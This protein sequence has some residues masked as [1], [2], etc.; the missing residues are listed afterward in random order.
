M[1]GRVGHPGRRRTPPLRRYGPDFTMSSQQSVTDHSGLRTRTEPE[2][3]KMLP[4]L[5]LAP[6]PHNGRLAGAWWPRTDQPAA[7][8]TVLVT[9][10]ASRGVIATRLSLGARAWDGTPG[11]IRFPDRDVRLIWF[12]HRAPHTVIVGYGADEI[13]LLVIPPQSTQKVAS[14]AF[15]LATDSGNISGPDKILAASEAATP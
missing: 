13:A 10:L 7:E 15:R 8:L 9:G 4:R 14:R 12:S 1:Q 2:E 3:A 11:R 5:E 6:T